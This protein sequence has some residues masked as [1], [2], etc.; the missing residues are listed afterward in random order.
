MRPR[1]LTSSTW[2]RESS[3]AKAPRVSPQQQIDSLIPAAWAPSAGS[4]SPRSWAWSPEWSGDHPVRP[5]VPAVRR[6]DPCHATRR[7]NTQPAERQPRP[8]GGPAPDDLLRPEC[9][10]CRTVRC[11]PQ[12]SGA[13]SRADDAARGRLATT[14]QIPAVTRRKVP[15]LPRRDPGPQREGDAT[16]PT[17]RSWPW[18]GGMIAQ[19]AQCARPAGGPWP[20]H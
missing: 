10:E 16:A 5:R 14:P 3:T 18:V 13:P 20:V 15:S 9:V 17:Q 19:S 12:D 8:V 11:P 2:A 4:S 7:R 1:V 6:P